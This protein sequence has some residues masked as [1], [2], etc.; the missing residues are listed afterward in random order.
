MLAQHPRHHKGP[1]RK[2]LMDPLTAISTR[3]NPQN[4]P[5]PGTTLNNAGGYAFEVDDWTRLHRFLILGTEGGTYHQGE[6][7][8]TRQNAACLFR[9]IASDGLRVVREII[10][11]SEAGR[12]PKQKPTLFA[13]AACAGADDDAT[14]AAALK[15]LARVCRT[16]SHLLMFAGYVE[17]FRGWGRGLRNAVGDWYVNHPTL[18]LQLAKYAQRGGWSQRDLLR[19]AKPRPA[20]GSVQDRAIGWAVGKP[21]QP[22]T[23]W[24]PGHQHAHALRVTG[25]EILRDLWSISAHERTAIHSNVG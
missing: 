6:T 3:T 23:P 16:G 25:K 10:E 4:Q 19:L 13:L 8:L 5:I 21:A 12:A 14:R 2:T 15:V 7:E 11:I 24:N 17:Q 20:S 9:C 22:G 1:E 18:E